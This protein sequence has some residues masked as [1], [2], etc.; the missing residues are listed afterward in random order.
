MYYS[1]GSPCSLQLFPPDIMCNR[2]SALYVLWSCMSCARGRREVGGRGG[3]TGAAQ[4]SGA[5]RQRPANRVSGGQL[6][7]GA[8]SRRAASSPRFRRPWCPRADRVD[9]RVGTTDADPGSICT[10]SRHER[11]HTRRYP[12]SR[13]SNEQIRHPR[14][15]HYSAVLPSP[16]PPPPSVRDKILAK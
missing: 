4:R 8:G 13:S 1:A 2:H 7:T 14:W 9:G 11:V 10:L 12:Q 15:P 3:G 5:Q 6:G 16:L